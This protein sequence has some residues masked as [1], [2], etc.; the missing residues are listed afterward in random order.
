VR[1]IA[2]RSSPDQAG[3][4]NATGDTTSIPMLNALIAAGETKS[5]ET[6][7]AL[8]ESP[9]IARMVIDDLKL[10]ITPA[11][12]L[13]HVAVKPITNTTLL[14]LSVNWRDR[15]VSARI[16][17]TFAGAFVDREREL[18]GNEARGA[19]AILS[20]Q[21][22]TARRTAAQLNNRVVAYER[23]HS[24]AD[25][26]AQTQ[27]TVDA[28][29]K[30]QAAIVQV[31]GDAAQAQA[32]LRSVNAQLDS[33][34]TNTLGQ[35][36]T[37]TNPVV[38]QLQQQ[39]AQKSAELAS[40]ETQYTSEHPTVI[41][42]RAEKEKLAREIEAQPP[43]VES[44]R[45]VATNPVYEKLGE[46]SATLQG[47]IAAYASQRRSLHDSLA[48]LEPRLHRLPAI[49]SGLAALQRDA[50]TAE[51]LY[52]GLRQKYNEALIAR[53]TALSD[54]MVTEPADAANAAI[55]PDLLVT[56]GIGIILGIILGITGAF[57]AELLDN[58]VKDEQDLRRLTSL[59]LLASI[60]R[61]DSARQLPKAK[62]ALTD[63][64]RARTID[65]FLQLVMSI[66]YSSERA[67]R[68][69]AVTSAVPGDGKSTVALNAAVAMS[70]A[71][72]SVL[73]V[74]TDLRKPSLHER[75]GLANNRGLSEVLVGAA[76]LGDCA[77]RTKYAGLDLLSAGFRAPNP[78][79]LF[80]S[81]RFEAMIDRALDE[82]Q[83]VIFDTPAL[84]AVA[85]A[86]LI[87]S[88]TDGTAVVVSS[89]GTEGG[90]VQRAIRRLESVAGV[91][92]IGIVLNNVADEKVEGFANY[93]YAVPSGVP[94]P[95]A[96]PPPVSSSAAG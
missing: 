26:G 18:V 49:A 75:L 53:A 33:T 89:G 4:V 9:R 16:A 41:R 67:L 56:S 74:D 78:F 23:A 3:S 31:D 27:S 91:N 60:P 94:L 43:L 79:A 65:A 52:G 50:K 28:I 2:G 35:V 29:A 45:V 44:E 1:L 17:N 66:R 58:R 77:Q 48:A 46:Q 71:H 51:N 70:T 62:A 72:M 68:T 59:P 96:E 12:L 55:R 57:V 76:P 93:E 30:L 5:P 24:I 95:L 80:Q 81:S 19:L 82:Y 47:E 64:L 37:Q 61:F 42:L 13:A 85:D 69:I 32:Q 15:D 7:V 84:L 36:R 40:A 87:A 25:I 10:K 92:L 11:G 83:V 88:K 34:D 21:L 73:L 54:V 20:N 86:A 38:Q 8:I 90:A 14:D 63:R 6:Y 22:K 39:F